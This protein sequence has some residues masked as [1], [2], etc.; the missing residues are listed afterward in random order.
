MKLALRF[1]LILQETLTRDQISNR[2]FSSSHDFGQMLRKAFVYSHCLETQTPDPLL[3]PLPPSSSQQTMQ[4]L[5]Q[6]GVF[7]LGLGF[8]RS[9]FC[10]L[11]LKE[12]ALLIV[13]L[14]I[15]LPSIGTLQ[16]SAVSAQH[17][18]RE[19]RRLVCFP[20]VF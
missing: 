14:K 20:K 3:L 9:L 19:G 13:G 2:Q 11:N 6:A 4:S 7:Y 10:P 16:L 15:E 12:R 5:Y 17:G 18:K 1:G 8:Y